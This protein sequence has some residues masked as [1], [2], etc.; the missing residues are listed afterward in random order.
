MDGIMVMADTVSTSWNGVST[1]SLMAIVDT[2]KEIVPLVLPV[3]V[4][5]IGLRKGLGFFLG[6][7]RGA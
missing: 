7:I 5:I 4:A 2:M 3:A 1:E 6:L